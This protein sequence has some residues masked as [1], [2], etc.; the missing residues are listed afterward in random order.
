M[1]VPGGRVKT[2][3]GN[4]DGLGGGTALEHRLE[5]DQTGGAALEDSG[6]GRT[7]LAAS[8]GAGNKKAGQEAGN[9]SVWHWKPW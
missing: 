1:D 5:D 8:R 9:R 3:L 6:K 2:E 4:S 7:S